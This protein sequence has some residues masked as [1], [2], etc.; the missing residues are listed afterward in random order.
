MQRANVVSSSISEVGYDNQSSTLEIAFADG[1]VYQYFDVP[2]NVHDD[3]LASDSIGK[4]FTLHV[5]GVY[6]FARV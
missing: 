4:F 5:R 2:P 6:R 3:L 1:K